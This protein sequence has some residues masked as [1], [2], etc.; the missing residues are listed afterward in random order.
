MVSTDSLVWQVSPCLD[1][2][3]FTNILSS[4]CHVSITLSVLYYMNLSGSSSIFV[5]QD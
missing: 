1:I 5:S 3:Y 2:I 4:P